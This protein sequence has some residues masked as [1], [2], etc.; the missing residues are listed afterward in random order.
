MFFNI[1]FIGETGTV[2]M[3]F[4]YVKETALEAV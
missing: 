3:Y 2:Y 1:F 4:Y